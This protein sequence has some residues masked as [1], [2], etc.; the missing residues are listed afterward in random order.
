MAG[1]LHWRTVSVYI[2]NKLGKV[3]LNIASTR[4]EDIEIMCCNSTTV[5]IIP[6]F[7][8]V[9]SVGTAVLILQVI[10]RDLFVT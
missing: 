5:L 2:N 8:S 1:D 7:H 10:I 6:V 9:P 3:N 4:P